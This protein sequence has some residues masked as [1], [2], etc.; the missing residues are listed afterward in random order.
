[1]MRLP[2]CHS[3]SLPLSLLLLC[4]ACSSTGAADASDAAPASGPTTTLEEDLTAARRAYREQPD[5]ILAGIWVGRRLAYLGR[6]EEAV[7]W[8]SQQ[9]ERHPDSVRLLRHRG[10]RYLSLRRYE[11]AVR[12]LSRAAE[13]MAG[14]EDRIEPDGAP[15]RYGVPRSTTQ[16]NVW[17]HLGLAHYLLGSF[18]EALAAYEE[19]L[20]VAPNGDMRVATAHW[21]FHTLRRLGREREARMLVAA[22]DP[23]EDVIENFAYRD[24]LRLY[25][26]EWTPRKVLERHESGIGL[27][28]AGYGVAAWRLEN[29]STERARGLLER[30]SREAPLAS[31]G[32]MAAEADLARL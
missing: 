30:I 2:T 18:E 22:I 5:S 17:Y 20:A 11:D 8:Y 27:A 28:S 4:A 1:M 26:A 25:R 3:L 13:L 29:G 16:S 6:Y 12:D 9:L 23:G 10:H 24:A 32:R 15:N 19:G 7:D 21:T 31:F 14:T